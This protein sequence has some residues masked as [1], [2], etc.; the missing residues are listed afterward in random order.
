MPNGFHYAFLQPMNAK[1][2][3]HNVYDIHLFTKS[4]DGTKLYVGCL[5]NGINELVRAAITRH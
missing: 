2:H 4:P 5:R 3:H 1:K